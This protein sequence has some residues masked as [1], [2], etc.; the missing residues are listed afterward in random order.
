MATF[1]TSA[2]LRPCYQQGP[3]PDTLKGVHLTREAGTA[4][5]PRPPLPP[6]ASS[7][8]LQQSERHPPLPRHG[9]HRGGLASAALHP[10]GGG[11][12]QLLSGAPRPYPCV[13]ERAGP[14]L[15]TL[16][17]LVPPGPRTVVRNGP[18]VG[19][20]RLLV[21]QRPEGYN[22]TARLVPPAH[23]PRGAPVTI[24][25]PAA[26]PHVDASRPGRGVHPWTHPFN[27]MWDATTAAAHFS[28]LEL[29]AVALALR[30][31]APPL[32]V[33]QVRVRS[34]NATTI[35]YINRQR[36]TVSLP[37]AGSGTSPP[38]RTGTRMLPV[39]GS[40]SGQGKLLCRFA[41]R[42]GLRLPK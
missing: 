25:P 38:L 21:A 11:S 31:P 18:P 20:Q 9:V 4:S 24:P 15:G 19:I 29:R 22:P 27:G 8:C 35:A 7:L 41:A 3:E 32:P 16:E 36:L 23:L 10:P 37:F 33:G 40:H 30:A 34:N 5:A 26:D 1:P 13:G 6:S 12:A 39:G 17:A 28:L 14:V 2:P 42:S